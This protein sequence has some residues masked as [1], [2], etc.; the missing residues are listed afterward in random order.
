MCVW[1]CGGESGCPWRQEEGIGCLVAGVIGRCASFDMGAKRW[2]FSR[3]ANVVKHRATSLAH[4]LL[5]QCAEVKSS[6]T[7]L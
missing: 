6:W 1:E 4:W 5:S 7:Y 2:S 3:A